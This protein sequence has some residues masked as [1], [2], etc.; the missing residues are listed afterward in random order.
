[1]K[2]EKFEEWNYQII[3]SA[4]AVPNVFGTNFDIVFIHAM[5]NEI[6]YF[7]TI[8]VI[9][10]GQLDSDITVILDMVELNHNKIKV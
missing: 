4:K 10:K 6:F 1:M 9:K 8:D 2:I 5:R 7:I 3:V